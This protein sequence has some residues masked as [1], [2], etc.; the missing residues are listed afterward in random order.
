M[1]EGSPLSFLIG[2]DQ[3]TTGTR[4]IAF[5][6]RFQPVAEAYRSVAVHHP[7]PGW[8]EKD[9]GEVVE[10][11]AATLADVVAEVGAERVAAIG[12]DNEGETTVAWD[13]DTLAPLAPAIVWSSRQSDPIVRRLAAA[14][15]GEEITQLAGTPLDPYFSA[16]KIRW[17]VENVPAVATAAEGGRLRC[18]TL[19]A[20][21][22]ARLCGNAATDPS[23]AAR[24]QLQALAEPGSWNARLCGLHGVEAAWLPPIEP[25]VGDLGALAV[26]EARLPLR[27]SLVDQTAALAGHGCLRP[28]T[29]KAT[30]GT[31]IFV[32][33]HAGERP[34]DSAGALLPTVA[35]WSAELRGYALDGGVFSAGSA[36]NWLRDGA[37]LLADPAESER[38]ARSVPDSGGVA[39]VPAL[40]GLGA[41]WWQPAAR[42]AW[43]G[44]S[45]HTTRA[46]LVRAVLESLAFRVRDVVEALTAA[47][48]APAE[49]RVDGGM[50][51]NRWLMEFQAGVL[52]IPVRIAATSEATALGAAAMAAFGAGLIPPERLEA[53]AEGGTVVE[54]AADSGSWRDTAY[55]GWRR[56]AEL[57]AALGREP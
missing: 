57:V 30:Y 48:A 10:A 49:L 28:G 50:T 27:A 43:T 16:T 23:T 14:G 21:I 15:L 45:A 26:G 31:G 52:G 9:A 56:S 7:Q 34:P 11:V 24:T 1:L 44:I 40:A 17:L 12:L 46:H 47:G 22:R 35:W 36:V 54:P 18:G 53:L 4:A 13:A 5:D 37:Q 6:E 3:G 2:V 19:D 42:A 51:A 20:L 32:L 33:A 25:S 39:F 41:P 55:A 8:D 38:L 29:V